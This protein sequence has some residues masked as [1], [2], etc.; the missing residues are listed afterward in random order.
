MNPYTKEVVIP[1]IV[2][3]YRLNANHNLSSLLAIN[4]L[5]VTDY[6]L[7]ANGVLVRC[8]LHLGDSRLQS[9]LCQTNRLGGC[10]LHLGDSRLHTAFCWDAL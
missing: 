8:D 7:N 1:K 2:T 9:Q 6:R 10:D 4:S 5:I 3:D